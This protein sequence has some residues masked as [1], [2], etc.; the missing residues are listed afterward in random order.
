MRVGSCVLLSSLAA[1]L[2]SGRGPAVAA[3]ITKPSAVVCTAIKTAAQLQAMQNNLAGVYCLANDIDA[4]SIANF[5]PIGA[6]PPYFTGRLYGNGHAIRNLTITSS[7]AEAGLFGK[8]LDGL[9]QNLGLINVKIT[10]A[11]GNLVGALAGAILG[12]NG[13]TVERVYA[14]GKV[15]CTNVGCFVGGLA[16]DI[17]NNVTIADAWS[18]VDVVGNG[19]AGGLV[20][21]SGGAQFIRSYATGHV[22]CTGANCSA[23]G[24]L[25][26]YLFGTVTE[27]YAA[28]PLTAG[29]NTHVGGLVGDNYGGL[30][31]AYAT[32]PVS[33]GTGAYAGSLV[34]FQSGGEITE[35][36]GAGKVTGAGAFLGGL[37][38]GF[39]GAPTVTNAYWDMTTTGQP[40][41]AAGTG[42]TTA[43]LR[44]ALPNG[45]GSAWGLTKNLSYPFLNNPDG[46]TS[47]LA[48]LVRA[49]RI[50]TFLPISQ[51]DLSQ[52]SSTP[53]HA[54]A[55]SQAAAYT[56]IA[57]AIGNTEGVAA[58]KNAKINTYWNDTVQNAHWT[59]TV[60]PYATLGSLVTLGNATLNNTNVLGVLKQQKL[61][62]LRGSYTPT[63]GGTA[64]HWMLGT[65][66]TPGLVIAN[67]PW[68]GSQVAINSA[69]KTVVSPT[70]F[71]LKNF[72]VNAYQSVTVNN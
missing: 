14:T 5:A 6:A 18:S 56:M 4:G 26:A 38:G 24:G 72:K 39:T 37:V 51:L 28:G 2:L 12:G 32:G 60:V 19:Y 54:A 49:A 3:G 40:T 9:I 59:G 64:T 66:Y 16:G 11:N 1:S 70:S 13:S 47:P 15:T 17:V 8:V 33:G 48:T 36:Y 55:A 69:T 34:G 27:S 25:V 52:Y 50:F 71:P 62:L 68:T 58:L 42:M 45:F 22:R 21:V 35:V 41:S 63:G 23:A 43:Q 31:R 29:A 30:L 20:G 10:T 57:R 53:A 67:D 65:L 7:G 61:V 46:F 44:G